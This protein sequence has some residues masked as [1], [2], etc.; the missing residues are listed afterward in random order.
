MTDQTDDIR[1]KGLA[2]LNNIE[3]MRL[4]RA[5]QEL[6]FRELEQ[7]ALLMAQGIDPALV[8]SYGYDPTKDNRKPPRS[9]G[10]HFGWD[11]QRQWRENHPVWNYVK[12][13]TGEKVYLETPIVAPRKA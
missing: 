10:F 1:A 9:S 13:E 12:M 2:I 11:A 5:K 8:K 4:L 7:L 6:L 3:Q